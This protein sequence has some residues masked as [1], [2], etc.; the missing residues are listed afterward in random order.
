MKR[1]Y[2]IR[3]GLSIGNKKGIVSGGQSNHALTKEGK[4]QAKLAG[5]GAKSLGI[6][7]IVSSTQ[8]RALQTA[9]FVAKEIGYP[10][11]NI[12]ANSL[13]V[14]RDFGEYEGV[15]RLLRPE[16]LEAIFQKGVKGSENDV[17]LIKRA[18][19][20]FAWIESLPAKNILVV[21][22]GSF[23]RCLRKVCVAEHDFEE[24][25]PNAE[26]VCWIED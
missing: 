17:A 26:I 20:A 8:L 1:L 10:V 2:F 13:L 15:T 14:E 24:R 5:Q 12:V 16:E 4:E 18:E 11:K 7:L 3:H 6:D 25:I 22:H 21:S 9:K 23:G 19:E